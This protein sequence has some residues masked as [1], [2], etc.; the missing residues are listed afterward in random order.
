LGPHLGGEAN[1]HLPRRLAA[2]VFAETSQPTSEPF[3][4]S[5]F[6]ILGNI[7]QY[8]VILPNMHFTWV[9]DAKRP[10]RRFAVSY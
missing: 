10:R 4:G 1:H 9:A 6:R 2:G 7:T 5:S 8:W 3:G